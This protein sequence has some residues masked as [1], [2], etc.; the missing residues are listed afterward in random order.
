[1]YIVPRERNVVTDLRMRRAY[2]KIPAL[3][4]GINDTEDD[5]LAN[6]VAPSLS[7]PRCVCITCTLTSTSHSSRA[8]PQPFLAVAQ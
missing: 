1:M 7:P 5:T 2:T 4:V 3:I 8:G 6:R